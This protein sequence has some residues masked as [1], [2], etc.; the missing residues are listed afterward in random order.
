LGGRKG[1]WPVKNGG[2]WRW[3]LVSLDGVAKNGRKTVVVVFS[4]PADIAP[5]NIGVATAYC[6]TQNRQAWSTLIGMA[7]S[8]TGQSTR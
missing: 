3:A 7:M 6:R 2:W 8:I 1:I 4:L 5:L